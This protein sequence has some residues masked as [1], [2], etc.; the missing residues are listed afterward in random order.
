MRNDTEKNKT[1]LAAKRWENIKIQGA[2]GKTPLNIPE[3]AE[4]VHP[5]PEGRSQG[6]A[7][8]RSSYRQDLRPKEEIKYPQEPSA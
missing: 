6:T 2:A 3:R 5:R 7:L 4:E 8:A 1:N